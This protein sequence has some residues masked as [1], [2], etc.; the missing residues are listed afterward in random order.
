MV[1]RR[2]LSKAVIAKFRD[3]EGHQFV[4]LG[5]YLISSHAGATQ[6]H[7]MHCIPKRAG[8]N[9]PRINLTFRKVVQT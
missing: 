1:I 7:W 9:A 6:D 2:Q 3:A 4:F 8:I 5:S